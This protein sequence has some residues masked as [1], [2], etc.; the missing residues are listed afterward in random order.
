MKTWKETTW[1]SGE[2]LLME[3]EKLENWKIGLTGEALLY[4]LL[5]K[6]LYEELDKNWLDS[7]IGDDVFAEIPFGE[8]QPEV[9]QGLE[10]LRRW[11][12]ENRKGIS[13]EEFKA[14]KKDQLYLFIGTDH[15][16]APVW[17]SVYFSEKRLV[18]QEQTLQVREWYSRFGLQPER[19]YREPD[20][21]IGLE[22]SFVA[23][24]ATMASQ[25]AEAQDEQILEET[26]KAQRG[27]LAE[28]LLRWGPAWARLV[29]KHAKTDFYRGLAHLT[30]GALIS[31]AEFLQV[32]MPK[33]VR[34]ES[35]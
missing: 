35:A 25:A 31:A 10:L 33:E 16:L 21:H 2:K 23:H 28:H 34:F 6:A 24:L 4:G 22:M 15:V 5:G 19:L 13:E 11:T 26:L 20:D 14:L 12:D 9:Q 30:D 18:F 27:F 3:R 7:L 32:E 8:G 1:F 17:E 29:K